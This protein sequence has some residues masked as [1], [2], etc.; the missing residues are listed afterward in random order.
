M[1]E[2][3]RSD[4]CVLMLST[5]FRGK[6][7]FVTFTDECSHFTTIFL[8]RNKSEVA[9]KSA[10]FLAFAEA[11]TSKVVKA[12]CCD[13][14]GEYILGDMTKFCKRR[15]IEHKF[16]PPYTPQLNGVAERMNRTLVECARCMIEYA[17][18]A[19]PYWVEAV[20]PAASLRN[21]CPTRALSWI[22]HHTL[23]GLNENLR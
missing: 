10:E 23:F 7:Y 15:G 12:F 13:N 8:L 21:R 11:Q 6:R 9:D 18:L 14:G 17:G 5:T 19:M 4:M 2:F 16:T 3:T 22:N 1:L 20:M